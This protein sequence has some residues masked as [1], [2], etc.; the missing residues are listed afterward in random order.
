M[1]TGIFLAE[2]RSINEYFLA[3]YLRE[4]ELFRELLGVYS[5]FLK[6][7]SGKIKDNDYPNWTILILLSQT[8]PLM[9]NGLNLLA[10]GYLRSSEIMIRVASEAII[11][12]TFFKEFPEVETEYR[13]LNHNA[14]FRNHRMPDILE[15]VEKEGNI[16]IKNKSKARNVKW[17]E[18]VFTNTYKEACRFVHNDPNVIY[19]LS[20]DNSSPDTGNLILGPQLYSDDILSMGLRRLFNTLLFSLVV[21]GVSLNIA[22][23]DKEKAVMEKSQKIIEA[24]NKQGEINAK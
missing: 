18:I 4:V 13:T 1:N 11:L 22:P 12:S 3:K 7:T 24:L 14:F 21:L 16:F 10:S 17:N 15:R 19:N 8:L 5:S 23:D 6:A 20:K 9:D 2:E